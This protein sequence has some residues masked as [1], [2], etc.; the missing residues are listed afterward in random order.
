METYQGGALRAC[1]PLGS[2]PT[3]IPPLYILKYSPNIRS[4]HQ[5]TFPPPQAF[6]PV[7]FDLGAF[8]HTLPEGDSI[9][10]GLYINLPAL[11]MMCE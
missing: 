1:G 8:S 5:N 6:V 11:P 4:V 3:L 9:T 7:R 10:E 2:P